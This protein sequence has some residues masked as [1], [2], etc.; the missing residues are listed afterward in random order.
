M[1]SWFAL[2]VYRER[3]RAEVLSFMLETGISRDQ[4]LEALRSSSEGAATRNHVF[5]ALHEDSGIGFAD[6]ARLAG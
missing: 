2:R 4:L 3:W 5:C 6:F 1:N